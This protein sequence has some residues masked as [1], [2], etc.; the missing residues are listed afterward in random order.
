[1]QRKSAPPPQKKN[2]TCPSGKLRTKLTSLI[3]K[4]T[5]PRLS[6][7]TF[8]ARYRTLWIS[9]TVASN[10]SKLW[11]WRWLLKMTTAQ[12][13]EMSVT[14]NNSSPVQDYVHLDDQTQPT[15]EIPYC[16]VFPKLNVFFHSILILLHL[17]N[18]WRQ[19]VVLKYILHTLM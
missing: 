14:V 3:A 17:C 6:D 8:S 1:M 10:M 19:H 13:V 4:S 5:S 11:L 15:F 12:V 18:F 16:W 9:F 7:T 2:S